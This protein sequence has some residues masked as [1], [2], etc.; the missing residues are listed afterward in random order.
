M[1][2]YYHGIFIIVIHN[3]LSVSIKTN[4][5]FP[6]IPHPSTTPTI[7]RWWRRICKIHTIILGHSREPM[8]RTSTCLIVT[9]NRTLL[10]VASHASQA[11]LFRLPPSIRARSNIPEWVINCR[12]PV[13]E[14]VRGYGQLPSTRRPRIKTYSNFRDSW[15]PLVWQDTAKTPRWVERLSQLKDQMSSRTLRSI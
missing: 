7:I 15:I 13:V 14:S 3:L 1:L 9:S 4:L 12:G 5:R 2:K 6:Y 8:I 10:V 11:K